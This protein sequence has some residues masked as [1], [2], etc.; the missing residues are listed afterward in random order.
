MESEPL[1]P[2]TKAA[3]HRALI[4]V[5]A[6]LGMFAIGEL[7]LHWVVGAAVE[8][9]RAVSVE[10]LLNHA[11]AGDLE[12][13]ALFNDAALARLH[14]DADEWL[15]APLDAG[16]RQRLQEAVRAHP[17]LREGVIGGPYPEGG[18][19]SGALV[20][21]SRSVY[22][23]LSIAFCGMAILALGALVLS[24]S[25]NEFV[26]VSEARSRARR[27]AARA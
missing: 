27:A 20:E 5:V 25:R 19:R 23:W 7:A 13:L 6:V 16:A 24:L 9:P 3:R 18:F 1:E 21:I 2:S 26:R 22:A 17:P 11:T 8:Q 14:G 15:R 12:E 10:A 4:Q